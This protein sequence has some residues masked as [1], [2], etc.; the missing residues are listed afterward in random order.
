MPKPSAQKPLWP[1]S[2]NDLRIQ[3][4][5][6]RVMVRGNS[7]KMSYCSLRPSCSPLCRAQ[8]KRLNLS[9]HQDFP[10]YQV[11]WLPVN[12]RSISSIWFIH[13]VNWLHSRMFAGAPP[14]FSSGHLI[15]LK[16]PITN[17]GSK[18]DC[19]RRSMSSRK[20]FWERPL[21]VVPRLW[22]ESNHWSA[23]WAISFTAFVCH[24]SKGPFF[25]PLE[26]PRKLGPERVPVGRL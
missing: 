21:V 7:R 13:W 10:L 24:A 18:M 1:L 15:A 25:L 17:H 22:L 5:K 23:F 12:P 19:L 3:E 2:C 20:I 6:K 26:I 11:N 14:F 16:S 4:K 9:V 8:S